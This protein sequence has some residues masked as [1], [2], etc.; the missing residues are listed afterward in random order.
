MK[1]ENNT[2]FP[3]GNV[4]AASI[5]PDVASLEVHEPDGELLQE[6][7]IV[8]WENGAE[9]R[10]I[11]LLRAQVRK[12]L[13]S[14]GINRIGITSAEPDA[15]K[16]FVTA[17]LAVALS[18]VDGQQ[19]ILFDLDLRR[20]TVAHRLGIDIPVGLEGWLSGDVENLADVGRRF[21]Q[22]SL[23]VFA[24]NGHDRAGD[25]IGSARFDLLI[26]ALGTLPKSTIVLCDLPPAFVSD[27]AVT[28]VERLDSYIHVIDE[29]ITPRRQV[30][31]LRAMM[32]PK[33]CLGAILNRYSGGWND[34][35]GYAAAR[36]YSR[37]YDDPKR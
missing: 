10:A 34:S 37:Y 5:I 20:P 15:G 23:S 6:N 3:V 28:I 14:Q 12:R 1:M 31:E 2:R 22:T 17:N 19:V 33:T 11:N 32:A 9:T 8:A 4:A 27:D 30:E 35:Y 16:S 18:R 7:G 26:T 24:T 29:G 36:K 25:L 21:G 13:E